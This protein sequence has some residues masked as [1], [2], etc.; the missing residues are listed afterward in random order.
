MSLNIFSD[1]PNSFNDIILIK[2]GE[3]LALEI[4]ATGLNTF[5]TKHNGDY[6][7][8]GNQYYIK[9][10]G[11]VLIPDMPKKGDVTVT[12]RLSLNGGLEAISVKQNEMKQYYR[13]VL[14][15]SDFLMDVVEFSVLIPLDSKLKMHPVQLLG[16]NILAF[17]TMKH[18]MGIQLS[19]MYQK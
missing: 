4:M 13:S 11:I 15:D 8:H 1:D 5:L 17:I 14:T 7:L 2:N 19:L 12:Y 6:E 9:S 16:V 10:L 18:P 3:D